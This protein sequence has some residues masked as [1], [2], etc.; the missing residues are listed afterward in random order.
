L[1][2]SQTSQVEPPQ[3]Q[4]LTVKD[5]AQELGIGTGKAYEIAN[6]KH[7]R[8]IRL[9]ERCI[10]IRRSD[11]DDFLNRGGLVLMERA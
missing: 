3:K 11:F 5:L 6:S 8:V 7:L 2:P 1:E 9:G 10:R 4:I